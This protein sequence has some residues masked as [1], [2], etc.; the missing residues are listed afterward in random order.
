MGLKLNIILG[1]VEAL[2]QTYRGM[3][4]DFR[5]FFK[6]QQG[7]F[8]G[9]RQTFEPRQG[10][11]DQPN[12]RRVLKV[13][14]TVDEKFDWFEE[15]ATEYIKNILSVEATN[16]SG[17]V[18]VPLVVDNVNL[19][20]Y[21]AI[22]LMRMKGIFESGD[23]DEMYKTIPVRSD[24]EIWLP[25]TEEMYKDR[26]VLESPEL[27]GVDKSIVKREKI[28]EDPNLPKMTDT[29]RYTPMKTVVDDVLELGDYTIKKF[30]GEASHRERA[31]ILLRKTKLLNA[32]SVAIKQANDTEMVETAFDGKKFFD[33]LHRG[34]VPQA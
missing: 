30:S 20:T 32:I 11:I 9:I 18:K 21:S 8:Q 13:V 33:Y 15:R 5:D 7:Q 16:A 2:G 14:T 34:V 10:T 28:L 17:L 26:N 1:K 19:G 31:E 6:G 29:S 4:K 23:L 24:S 25:S 3:V 27:K 22:E 12:K